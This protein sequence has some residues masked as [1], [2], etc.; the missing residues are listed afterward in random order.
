MQ[1]EPATKEKQLPEENSLKENTPNPKEYSLEETS[2]EELPLLP[3]TRRQ[4]NIALSLYVFCSVL[5]LALYFVTNAKWTRVS[6]RYNQTSNAL[7][8]P[9]RLLVFSFLHV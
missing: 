7:A 4:K 9:H 5:G 3:W 2:S 1:I 6:Y 8:L